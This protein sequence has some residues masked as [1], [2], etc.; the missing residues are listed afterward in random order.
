VSSGFTFQSNLCHFFLGLCSQ[1]FVLLMKGCFFKWFASFVKVVQVY[2]ICMHVT[3]RVLRRNFLN[4][5]WL[6]SLAAHEL[7]DPFSFLFF[8]EVNSL[9]FDLIS[10]LISNKSTI[11][12]LSW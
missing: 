4:T 3:V 6:S 10:S 11:F 1:L 7:N 8:E 5:L 12:Y 2:W 9:L